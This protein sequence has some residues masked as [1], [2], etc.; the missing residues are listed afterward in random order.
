MHFYQTDVRYNFKKWKFSKTP[1]QTLRDGSV[2]LIS[3]NINLDLKK[4]KCNLV[5]YGWDPMLMYTTGSSPTVSFYRLTISLIFLPIPKGAGHCYWCHSVPSVTFCQTAGIS[6]PFIFGQF[7]SSI[8]GLTVN[9]SS[10][11]WNSFLFFCW[12]DRKKLKFFSTWQ[13]SKRAV[14]E[15]LYRDIEWQDKG[16]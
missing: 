9:I 10:P 15:T 4:K 3:S 11:F 5:Q 7:T 13:D 6:M 1:V 12:K 16:E 2:S 14:R 8:K